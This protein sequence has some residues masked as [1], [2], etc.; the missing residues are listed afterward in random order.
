[1]ISKHKIDRSGVY[2]MSI[3]GRIYLKKIEYLA[4]LDPNL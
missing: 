3:S 4:L 2:G 1:M